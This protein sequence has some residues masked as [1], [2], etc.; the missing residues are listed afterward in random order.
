MSANGATTREV[1]AFLRRFGVPADPGAQAQGA[2]SGRLEVL[3]RGFHLVVGPNEQPDLLAFRVGGLVRAGPDD[4]PADRVHGLLLALASL[5][6]RIPLGAFAYDPGDGEVSLHYAMP[7]C[8]HLAYQ[9]FARV[10]ETLQDV[11]AGHA[12]DLRAVV[13]GEKLARE[14]L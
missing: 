7:V 13:A 14:I 1:A 3:G 12:A 5:N 11:L 6:S 8:G 4:T 9:D 2:A 10:L